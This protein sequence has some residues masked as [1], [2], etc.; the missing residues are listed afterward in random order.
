V[1]AATELGIPMSSPAGHDLLNRLAAD[2]SFQPKPGVGLDGA[3]MTDDNG[4]GQLYHLACS[5]V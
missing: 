5:V 3:F 2:A 1:Q 4:Q